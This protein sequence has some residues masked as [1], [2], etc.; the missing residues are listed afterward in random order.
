[1]VDIPVFTVRAQMWINIPYDEN[2]PNSGAELQ[3]HNIV[4]PK[5]WMKQ[6]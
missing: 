5:V 6:Q 4:T 1:M 3:W 2:I